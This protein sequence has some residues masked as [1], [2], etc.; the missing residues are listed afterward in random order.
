MDLFSCYAVRRVGK[1][2]AGHVISAVHLYFLVCEGEQVVRVFSN[3][4]EIFGPDLD[5]AGQTLD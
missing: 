4:Y 1:I 2:I 3:S 5:L